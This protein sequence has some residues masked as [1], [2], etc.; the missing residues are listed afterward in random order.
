MKLIHIYYN[1]LK[2]PNKKARNFLNKTNLTY[3]LLY[4]FSLVIIINLPGFVDVLV[5][6]SEGDGLF[7]IQFLV[8]GP[9]FAAF[10][11]LAGISLIT[12]LLVGAASVLQRKLKYQYLWKM[13]VFSLPLPILAGY[14]AD[15]I[16]PVEWLPAAAFL[17][18]FLMIH[19]KLIV[20]F[21][22]RKLN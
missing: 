10:A 14:T 9:F 6:G 22:K 21:P 3:T 16:F 8:L 12:V 1:A 20:D 17:V 7:L 13:A 19:L 11:V 4:L 15:L 5:N 2:L 18:I